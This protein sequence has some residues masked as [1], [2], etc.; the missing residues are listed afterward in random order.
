MGWVLVTHPPKSIRDRIRGLTTFI[1]NYFTDKW[2]QY[3]PKGHLVIDGYSICYTL[4]SGIDWIQGGQYWEY[5]Q[6][7]LEFFHALQASGI[8]PVVVFDGIDYKQVKKEVIWKRRSESVKIIKSQLTPGDNTADGWSV[9]PLQIMQVFREVLE[10]KIS[11]FILPMGRQL[12]PDTVAMAAH[13]KCPIISN[14]SDYFMFNF[15]SWIHPFVSFS[16]A[17]RTHSS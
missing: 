3:D 4:H 6:E 7:V 5:R 9:I 15:R 11:H 16:M 8:L 10:E 17:E 1:E 13:Y 12:H 2:L 14:D